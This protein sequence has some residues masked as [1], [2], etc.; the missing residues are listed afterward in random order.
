MNS[1]N[2]KNL[3]ATR[4]FLFVSALILIMS[5]RGVPGNPT[6]DTL[7][8]PKWKEEGP[9]E[10][11]PDRGRFA[12]TY[13]VV[14]DHSFFFSIPVA[15]FTTPD[16]GYANGKYVSL[17]APGLS[18][19]IIPGYLVGKMFGASQFGAFLVV[20][21][22]AFI[23]I[24]LL[25]AIAIRLGA[26]PIAAS[27]GA[28]VF[29]FASP[30]YSYAAT[31]Y[32]HH[33]STFLILASVYLLIRWDT[34]WS[35]AC[36]WFL[37]ATSLVVDYPNLFLMF[38]VGLTALGR[39]IFVRN[40][41]LT[42][43]PSRL[44]TFFAMIVPILFF[45]W[46]NYS[47]YDNPLQL[48]GTIESI[49]A[50]DANGAPTSSA[51]AKDLDLVE[52]ED[53]S[54]KKRALGFF[55]TRYLLNGLYVHLISPDR[56]SI[57]YA[58]AA[59]F[60]ILGFFVL[61]KTVPWVANMFLGIIGADLLLYSMWGDPYG[62][63]AFGSRYLIPTY[64]ILGIAVALALTRWR[65][66]YLFLIAFLIVFASSVWINALGAITSSRNP[67]QVEVLGL[68]QISQQQEK[69]TYERNLDYL[70]KNKAKSFI[71]QTIGKKYLTA[72]QYHR[73]LVGVIVGMITIL[74]FSFVFMYREENV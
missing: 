25:R 48:S 42:I 50:L 11:S 7:N 65:K 24:V 73:I 36:V 63:W 69:Y 56:G 15:R 35:L 64:A 16:L 72:A 14:E 3:I 5:V 22:F 55:K 20:T 52:R 4:L 29:I 37:S 44:L 66:N 70:N 49:E 41:K 47:S 32:Q 61:Y 74:L 28:A 53:I 45:L 46:F 2:G 51:M 40:G 17:F 68:E 38:P 30:A 54:H 1:V 12:L 8:D 59:L 27:I 6:A 10:L 26:H 57:N 62:G 34:F 18:F 71:F 19:I 60:G 21:F 9:L 43:R 67:P 58:A 13:S 39:I 33:V 23:N 31:L